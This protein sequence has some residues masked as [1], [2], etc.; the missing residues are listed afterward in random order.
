MKKTLIAFACLASCS[1]STIYAQ[2]FTTEK[3]ASGDTSAKVG[4][5]TLTIYNKIKATSAPVT[6]KWALV[7]NSSNIS[8]DGTEWLLDGVC[9]NVLCYVGKPLFEG[10]VYTTDPY[11]DKS[12]QTFYALFNS[13]N[14]VSGST[15][16]VQISVSDAAFMGTMK[17]FTFLGSKFDPT[18]IRHT[19]ISDDDVHLFPNP[20][21]DI[22]TVFTGGN[23]SISSITVMGIDGRQYQSDVIRDKMASLSLQS[24]AKG[25][26]FVLLKNEQGAVVETK[27][28]IHD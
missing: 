1:I 14:A 4:S 23:N 28:F 25:T 26:Y 12:F 7:G 20:A 21:G 10:T 15:A 19:T 2:T 27:R 8:A 5:G 3:T 11:D 24:L 17:T 6:L 16:W 22:L 9:D 18:G 13:D